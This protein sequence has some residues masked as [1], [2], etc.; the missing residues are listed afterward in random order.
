MELGVHL[1]LIDFGDGSADAT[2]LH[3]YT[4]RAADLGFRTAAANDHLVFSRPWTDGLAALAAV[5]S[6]SGSMRLATTV[7]LPVVRGPVAFAKSIA[8]ID[9]LS[10]GRV[11]AGVGPGS[12]RRDYQLVGIDFAERWARFDEALVALR[13]LWRGDTTFA[14]RF[15]ST[16]D[17]ELLPPPEQ[18]D[19][20]PLW[21]GSWGSGAGL[22]RVARFGDG[23][24][25]S[26]YNT[27]PEAFAERRAVLDGLLIAERKDPAAFPA[28]LATMFCYLSDDE[29]E[30]EQTFRERVAPM[31]DRPADELRARLLFGNAERIVH[32]LIAWR[33]AGV[34]EVLLWPVRDEVRQL[35]RFR[36]QV[37]PHIAHDRTASRSPLTRGPSG[38]T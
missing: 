8:A 7:G 3:E 9:R 14:G 19:G 4:E 2:L 15:Y 22:R 6:A 34:H 16:H 29:D 31:L 38:M 25:A 35:E 32:E 33:D 23:W 12:S 13:A 10:G 18:T 30:A 21:I 36:E 24:L 17:V 37:W 1:P 28:V 26:A 5:A 27:T 20:P 11:V